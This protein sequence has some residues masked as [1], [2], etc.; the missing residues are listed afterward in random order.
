MPAD[1]W[2]AVE[3]EFAHAGIRFA[4]QGETFPGVLNTG[5]TP[6]GW[7]FSTTDGCMLKAHQKEGVAFLAA[8]GGR[9]LIADDMGVGKTATLIAFAEATKMKRIVVVAPLTALSHWRSEIVRWGLGGEIHEIR[10]RALTEVPAT[11]RWLLIN[12]EMLVASRIPGRRSK[13]KE[14]PASRSCLAIARW[15]ATCVVVDEAHRAKNLNAARTRATALLAEQAPHVV[16]LTGTPLR[17]RPDE[18]IILISL[19]SPY[20]RTILPYWQKAI[21]RLPVEILQKTAKQMLA[22]RMLRRTK[23]E[24]LPDLAALAHDWIALPFAETDEVNELLAQIDFCLSGAKGAGTEINCFGAFS[25]A[26]LA[27]GKP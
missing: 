25:K 15:Q 9:A 7:N 16:L 17:N 14:V 20:C 6:P 8:A 26:L 22:A 5:A 3:K 1:A 2:R 23:R 13:S 11:A 12:Y 10:E 21:P 18:V 4:F 27:L 19:L 24:V